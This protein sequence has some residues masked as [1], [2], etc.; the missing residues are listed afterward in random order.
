MGKI[1]DSI[2]GGEGKATGVGASVRTNGDAAREY[3]GSTGLSRGVVGGSSLLTE[4]GWYP[5]EAKLQPFLSRV[6]TT[7]NCR[8]ASPHPDP[9]Q[10]VGTG[11]NPGGAPQ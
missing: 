10:Q 2:A 9:P 3:S 8:A 5:A 7:D 11:K 1:P 6:L 4:S